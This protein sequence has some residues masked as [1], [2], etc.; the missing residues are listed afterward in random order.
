MVQACQESAI[1][2]TKLNVPR[3]S[4]PYQ[5]TPA[6]SPVR[7]TV[8]HPGHRSRV[9]F[10]SSTFICF[11][12]QIDSSMVLL[13]GTQHRRA[14]LPHGGNGNLVAPFY[15]SLQNTGHINIHSS[16]KSSTVPGDT[17]KPLCT[18]TAQRRNESTMAWL[19]ME[20]QTRPDDVSP[21]LNFIY[22]W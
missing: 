22:T 1:N 7:H 6:P 14:Q 12:Q 5:I 8:T 13:F 21:G 10:T 3:S 4:F 17:E 18:A 20:I 19:L 2:K 9:G 11:F 16:S 15:L